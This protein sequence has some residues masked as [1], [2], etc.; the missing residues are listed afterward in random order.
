M[1]GAPTGPL[2]VTS[3]TMRRPNCPLSIRSPAHQGRHKPD[4]S[5]VGRVT[6]C[7][8]HIASCPPQLW[9]DPI[10]GSMGRRAGAAQQASVRPLPSPLCC[11]CPAP[12]T[13]L[14]EETHVELEASRVVIEMASDFLLPAN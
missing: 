2:Q 7:P 6:V 10:K 4:A 11:G 13:R 9:R 1:R 3:D 8:F 5:H 12:P 14:G